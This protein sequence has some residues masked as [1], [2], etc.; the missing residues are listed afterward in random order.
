MDADVETASEAGID[1]S[2]DGSMHSS[3]SNNS[4]NSS[5]KN[6]KNNANNGHK[7]TPSGRL[8]WLFGGWRCASSEQKDRGKR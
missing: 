4:G 8:S 2:V 3:R 7:D 5:G 1:D 6:S